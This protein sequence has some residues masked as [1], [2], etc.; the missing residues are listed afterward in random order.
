MS[1]ANAPT[2]RPIRKRAVLDDEDETATIFQIKGKPSKPPPGKPD[3]SCT[4][5]TA[6]DPKSRAEI[7]PAA[8]APSQDQHYGEGKARP[9]SSDGSENPAKLTT[10]RKH[11][12]PHIRTTSRFDYQQGL[13]KDYNET[14]YCGFGDSCIFVHDRGSYKT[15]WE[16]EQEWDEAQKKGLVE[17]VEPNVIAPA[18]NT[19][20]AVCDTEPRGPRVMSRCLH[21]FCEECAIRRSAHNKKC[22]VCGCETNGQFKAVPK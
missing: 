21:L 9:S 11:A 22:P 20:C 7:E 2:K 17:P 19:K 12:T 16:L 14:G 4:A 8:F 13:C 6:P 1:D 15:G 18:Q 3:A 10:G 5:A